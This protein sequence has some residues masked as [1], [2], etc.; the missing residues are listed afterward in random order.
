M[1]AARLKRRRIES[2][3][4]APDSAISTSEYAYKGTGESL[5]AVVAFKKCKDVT[6]RGKEKPRTF[7]WII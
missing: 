2:A 4:K 6:L 1:G 5:R 3:N 7:Y